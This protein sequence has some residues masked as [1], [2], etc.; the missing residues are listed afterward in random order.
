MSNRSRSSARD[1]FE[2]EGPL[3]PDD[4]GGCRAPQEGDVEIEFYPVTEE[5]FIEGVGAQERSHRDP[6]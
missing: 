6:S 2:G 1:D 4:D 3:M 5:E